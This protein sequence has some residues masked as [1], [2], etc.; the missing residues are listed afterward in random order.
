[1]CR[2]LL[3]VGAD[4]NGLG[5]SYEVS[6]PLGLAAA[7]GHESV[8]RLLLGCAGINVDK[9]GWMNSTP[10]QDAAS[11]GHVGVMKLLLA[12][13]GVNVNAK[14]RAGATALSTAAE[15]GHRDAVQAL[16]ACHDIDVTIQDKQGS[17][18]L[19]VAKSSGHL[20]VAEDIERFMTMRARVSSS[21]MNA[22]LGFYEAD[23]VSTVKWF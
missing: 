4:P 10:L 12:H 21:A 5:N 9:Y 13:E 11:S 2:V 18:A 8:V 14:D 20:L 23:W 17:T 22:R 1:M 3:H 7:N 19:E 6:Q 15:K 16:L